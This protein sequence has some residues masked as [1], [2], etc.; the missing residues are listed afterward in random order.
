RPV[1]GAGFRANENRLIYARYSP[2]GD[3]GRGRAVHNSYLQVLSDHGFV[4]LILF[5]LIFVLAICNC[6]WV[7]KTCSGIDELYWLAYLAG[8]LEI[9]LLGFAVGAVA[10]SM[11]YY[12]VFIVLIAVSSLLREHVR[13]EVRALN[14][15]VEKG[16]TPHRQLAY[17]R[18]V[19]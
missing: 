18:A 2:S 9:S 17:L 11:A 5:A 4:G 7:K 8:M 16:L 10:L 15:L 3:M 12:D 19:S 1:F 14:G 13:R 6:R